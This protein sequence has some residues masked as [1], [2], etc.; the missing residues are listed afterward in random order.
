MPFEFLSGGG[1]IEPTAAAREAAANLW[2]W[3]AA[4][5]AAGFTPDQSLFLLGQVV[6]GG[7]IGHALANGQNGGD[8]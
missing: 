4:N 5:V 8:S 6:N 7:A 1:P 2:Q 3:H